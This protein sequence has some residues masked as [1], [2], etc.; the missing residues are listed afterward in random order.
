MIEVLK[1]DRTMLQR[2]RLY[3][4][5]TKSGADPKKLTQTESTTLPLMNVPTIVHTCVVPRKKCV[6]TPTLIH[7]S[8]LNV[9]QKKQTA[10]E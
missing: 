10:Q 5:F 7:A 3:A 4:A 6:S 1:V 9:I 8:I 2:S